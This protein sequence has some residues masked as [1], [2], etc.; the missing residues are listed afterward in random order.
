MAGLAL[1]AAWCA[2]GAAD[3]QSG[4]VI[5][6]AGAINQDGCEFCCGFSCQQTP[7]P[8][9][10]VE[11]GVRVFHVPSGQFLLVIEASPG[12][13]LRQPGSEGVFFSTDVLPITHFSGQPS[14]QVLAEHPMGNGSPEFDCRTEPI[15]G[16]PGFPELDFSGGE[17]VNTALA[18]TACR[19]ELQTSTGNACTRDRFGSFSF[20]HPSTTRQYCF[21]VTT[22][23]ELPFGPTRFAVRLRD[24][25]GNLGPRHEFIVR[26]GPPGPTGTPTATPTRTIFFSPTHTPTRTATWTGTATRT[27]TN[28]RTATPTG[29]ATFTR[30]P[31]RTGTPTRTSTASRTLTPT[32]TPTGPTRTPTPAAASRSGQVRYYASDGPV[33]N[34]TVAC[35]GAADQ[36]TG[37]QANGTYAL[38]GLPS[39]NITVE[40]KKAGDL[41]SPPAVTAFDAA[42]VLRFVAGD[43]GFTARERLAC[44]VSGD[45][46]VSAFDAVYI[47]QLQVGTITRLPAAT[48]CDSDWLF[49]PI[50]GPAPNQR[51]IAP[52]LTSQ[53]CRQGAIAYEPMAGDAAQQDFAGI[54]FGD[55]T[56]NWQPGAQGAAAALTRAAA[57][58]AS[59]RARVARRNRE[60][61]LR[62]AIALDAVEPFVSADFTVVYG[63]G[64]TA[65]AVRPLR[66]AGNALIV[67]NLD[68]PGEVRIAL[69]NARPMPAGAL[70]VLE[71][72]G[73]AGV[74]PNVRLTRVSVD[75]APA[76]AT[77]RVGRSVTAD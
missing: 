23:A 17:A 75:D 56:G 18:E 44:D 28:T 19:F 47:L 77:T 4:P 51:L 32:L 46:S 20:V 33:P 42:Q 5:R 61:V 54:L 69:A 59:A 35:K 21:Q 26:V 71:F 64:L 15:G 16:V 37:T 34:A 10:D 76:R 43:R 24:T 36:S 48:R 73:P 41:G 53:T 62:V 22:T 63:Q 67:T 25:N 8:T 6:F 13:S 57:P 11:E 70:L 52:L 60:G 58:A 50:P 66:A 27:G 9:P 72:D 29:T 49:D 3:A 14:L 65:R 2:A 74:V 68:T 1:A 45:G 40:P 30:T 39:G 38:T 55:C 31:T 7:T 12:T